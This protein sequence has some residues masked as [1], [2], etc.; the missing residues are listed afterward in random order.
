VERWLG[1]RAAGRARGGTAR[2]GK[3]RCVGDVGERKLAASAERKRR[4]REE[5]DAD[6]LNSF[7]FG[8]RVNDR[9]K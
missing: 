6:S 1:W 3:G 2:I 7:I 5:I 9:R 4:S 8:D